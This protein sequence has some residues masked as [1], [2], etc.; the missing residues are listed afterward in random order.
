MPAGTILLRLACLLLLLAGCGSHQEAVVSLQSTVEHLR[1]GVTADS[2][3]LIFRRNGT[4]T[5]LEAEFAKG[6]ARFGNRKLKFVELPWSD[7]IPALVDGR[8]DI[9]MSGMTITASRRY[10][11]AFS[12]PYMITGQVSL[13]RLAD[14]NRFSNGFT[15][16]L[17]PTVTIGTVQGTTGNLFIEKN[18]VRAK[19]RTFSSPD[20]GV[21]ALLDKE[22]DVFVY[23][24]PMNFHA[25]AVHE[26]DGLTAVVTPMTREALAWGIRRDDAELLATANRYLDSLKESGA[27]QEMIIRWVPFY[28]QIYDRQ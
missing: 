14:L 18:V 9:I 16:L 19:K 22:I 12:R 7:L 5:G 20:R 3:P 27:L 15:D 8:I 1:V 10:R 25:A 28:R 23:D 13:V 17:N 21:Q 2:P 4:I 6:L 26:Q 24:L 11:I